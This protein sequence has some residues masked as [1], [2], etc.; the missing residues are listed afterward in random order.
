MGYLEDLLATNERVE[1][2]TRGHWTG[3]VARL[4]VPVLLLV[5]GIAAAIAGNVFGIGMGTDMLDQ[6]GI[7]GTPKIV[8]QLAFVLFFI[9]YPLVA[10]LLQY[11]Y[12]RNER[13][14]VTNF[15]LIHLHGV[16][17][18]DVRDSSLEKVNDIVTRQSVLGRM[19]DYG[20][21]T[22]LTSSEAMG[23]D[24]RHIGRPL[25]F[26]TAI[27]EAKQRLDSAAI[28]GGRSVPELLSQLAELRDRGVVTEE[29]FER[30]KR[31]LLNRM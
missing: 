5:V 16:L 9:A 1:A 3:L 22:I 2:S 28:A 23:S 21:L 10:L 17:R 12:W 6:W 20:D 29:E 8:V 31:Q 13:Y 11:L 14:V 18:K 25:H 7:R 4:F 30:E 24:L 26:K 15:R 27:V 19:M